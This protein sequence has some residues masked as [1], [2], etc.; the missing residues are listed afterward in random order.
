[1]VDSLR[2]SPD[3]AFK[4]NPEEDEDDNGVGGQS[5]TRGS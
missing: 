4:Y 5:M 1:M 3:A 2:Y